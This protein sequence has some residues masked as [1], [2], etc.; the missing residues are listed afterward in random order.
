ME[1]EKQIVFRVSRLMRVRSD[2]T[3]NPVFDVREKVRLWD[4][5][6]VLISV[7]GKRFFYQFNMF[8]TV[9]FNNFTSDP[10]ELRDMGDG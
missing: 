8:Y 5:R 4:H 1:R 7:R 2:Q 6:R 10:E 3:A 9:I